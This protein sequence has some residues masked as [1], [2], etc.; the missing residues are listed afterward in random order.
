MVIPIM[1]SF[2]RTKL[3]TITLSGAKCVKSLSIDIPGHFKG[4]PCK[5]TVPLA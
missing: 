3:I 2:S 5:Y 1:N 4:V